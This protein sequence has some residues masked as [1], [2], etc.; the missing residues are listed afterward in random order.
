M[1]SSEHCNELLSFIKRDISPR[2]HFLGVMQIETLVDVPFVSES[3]KFL[4]FKSFIT[5]IHN[6]FVHPKYSFTVY[7]FG[8]RIA[9]SFVFHIK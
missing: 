3:I 4:N 1:G 2:N 7:C 8:T 9:V 5:L 6:F